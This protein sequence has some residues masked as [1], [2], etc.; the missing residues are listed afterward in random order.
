MEFLVEF[1]VDVPEGEAG[2]RGR[3]AGARR[4]RRC[5]ESGSLEASRP[6]LDA[7][8]R[9]IFISV[10]GRQAANVIYETYLVG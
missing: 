9:S 7:P 8:C 5:R 3:T 2:F 1:Q 6:A 4:G 10:G